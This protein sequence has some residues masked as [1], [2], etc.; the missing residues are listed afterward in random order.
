[1]PPQDA[2]AARWFADHLEPHEP[3][4][5]GYLHGQ[6]AP[7][8]IDD[9]VQETYR[10]L[11]RARE[12]GPI[13][14]PR[15]LLFATARNVVR[16]LHRRRMTAQ[17]FSVTETDV[18]RVL[19]Q[20]PGVAETVTRRQEADLLAAAIQALPPRCREILVLRKYENLSHREIA[21]QLGIAEHTVEAQLTKALH[22]CQEFFA[23][24]GALPPGRP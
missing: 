15:G 19:D 1:M 11:L 7:S 3:V 6:V 21:Q 8:E 10:H 14:S 23:R 22:R 17:T 16:D 5:R 13:E 18:S 9:V 24:Q 4:L 20:A 2:E 12:R